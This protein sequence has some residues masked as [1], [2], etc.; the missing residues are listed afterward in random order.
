[1]L[2]PDPAPGSIAPSSEREDAEPRFVGRRRQLAAL[3]DAFTRAKRGTAT[4]VYVNGPSGIGKSALVEHFLG[5]VVS[6]ED[7]VVLR[8]RCYERESVP[9]KALDGVIDSLSHHLRGLPWSQAEGLMPP[10]LAPLLR[11]FPVMLQ[12]GAVPPAR[13]HERDNGDPLVLRQRAFGALRDL[14]T[15]IAARRPVAIVIDDLHWADAD[16][17]VL[18]E[19]LLRPPHAP[20]IL[21]IACFRLEEV[22]SKPFLQALLERVATKAATG[23]TLEP[24]PDDEARM[25]LMSAIA[26]N[27]TVR[28]Q[29]AAAEQLLTGGH[30]DRGLDVITT[31]L[32]AVRLRLAR[33]MR[34]AIWSLIWY[35]LRLYWRGL[36]FVER[37]RDRVPPRDLLRIDTCWSVAA[38][39]ALVDHVRAAD[40]QTR[41]LLLALD[42][43]EPHRIARALAAEVVFFTGAGSAGRHMTI[44]RVARA[45]AIAARIGSPHAIALCAIARG[46]SA[47][48]VGDWPAALA[49]CERGLDLLRNQSVTTWE[50][51]NIQLFRLAALM[52]QGE[53]RQVAGELPALL[54]S[55]RARGNLY[56]ETE[57]RTRMHL[58][59]LM[60]DQPA[61]GQQQ[62]EDVMR[63]WSHAGFHRQHYNYMLDRVQT[64]LY[65]GRAPV[66]WKVITDDWSAVQR[67][68][69][70]RVQFLRIEAWYLRARCALLMA[71][72]EAN[73][74]KFL[75]I[76]RGAARR[77]GREKTLWSHPLASLLMA[78]VAHLEAKPQLA[79]DNLTDAAAGFE[80]A[81]MKLYTAVARR[82]LGELSPDAV[83]QQGRQQANAWMAA[84]GIVSPSR[85][86]R[87]IAPGFRDQREAM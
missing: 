78:A 84:Q 50:L 1:M 48:F 31:I 6:R 11:L 60:A 13:A 17:A 35:R 22:E 46:A 70:L 73:G 30:I 26:T 4:S 15:R 18:L 64:E 24:M 41:H 74:G 67:A 44:D 68:H 40:F 75:A 16:S 27:A 43:G 72:R 42:A 55:A 61:E 76:A 34:A 71:A 69:L 87:L 52:Y 49:H 8:G 3:E 36:V 57:L 51:N 25:L 12:A 29:R 9:Y 86:T 53:L 62:A 79:R 58:L 65:L 10:D 7:I 23:L 5:R 77:I 56:F 21:T 33:G 54:D 2:E 80:R 39:L 81:Q 14:L 83:S 82:R 45:E 59:W 32:P 47:F 19:D 63:Q 28:L 38:G 66:A 37:E 20:P 85:M